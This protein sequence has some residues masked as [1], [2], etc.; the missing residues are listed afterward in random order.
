[1]PYVP[2][3]GRLN[4]VYHSNNVFAN[5]VPIALWQ[6][7]GGTDALVLQA[8][9]SITTSEDFEKEK[10]VQE[11]V[12]GETEDEYQ[13]TQ[14][15]KKLIEAGVINQDDLKKG[16]LAGANPAA[17]DP[18]VGIVS[19]GAAT[20]AT[21]VETDVDNTIL[22]VWTAIPPGQTTTSTIYVKTVTKQ[23]G[24]IFPYDVKTV[25]PE[26]GMSVQ[27]VCDNLRA[28]VVNC[29][30]P[31]KTQ[32]PDAFITCSFR[33][34]G[35]GSPTSQHPRGMAMDIQ[36]A[37][38]TKADY[39]TRAQWVKANVPY[40][41]FILEYKTTGTGKPWHHISFNRTG[42]RGQCFTYM[43]DKNCQG[44]GV[45]GLYDLSNT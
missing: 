10:A 21:N 17:S 16:D 8:M 18:T 1:M 12:E 41:Q 19:S 36:Y 29:W 15:Q 22:Y 35:V 23:P 40:D 32:F 27:D 28:L 3:T 45:Q 43:N 9:A 6:P 37:S 2:G 44:P 25:A 14:Q 24:V 33:K 39:Y 7:Q 20:T 13:V 38:A 34:G 11:A 31:I 42:N 4:D 5:F 30:V 26:N